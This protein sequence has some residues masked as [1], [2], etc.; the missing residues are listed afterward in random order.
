MAPATLTVQGDYKP[1]HV[2]TPL[3]SNAIKLVDVP[4]MDYYAAQGKLKRNIPSSYMF[5]TV[6]LEF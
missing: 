2:G 5:L 4:E 3:P 6:L 1:D